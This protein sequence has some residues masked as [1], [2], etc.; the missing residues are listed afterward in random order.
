MVSLMYNSLY[1]FQ[2]TIL[3]MFVIWKCDEY[4]L[5]YTHYRDMRLNEIFL[6]H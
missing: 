3:L 5:V 4:K 2:L 6:N 1:F